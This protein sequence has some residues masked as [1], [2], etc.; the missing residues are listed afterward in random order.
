MKWWLIAVLVAACLIILIV[1]SAA[2]FNSPDVDFWM[3]QLKQPDNVYAS[4]CG[5]RD[6][7][8]ADKTDACG[9]TDYI[10]ALFGGCALVAI[11]T[12]TR[13]MPGRCRRRP[14]AA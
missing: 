10:P 12:D 3:A 11:I 13:I 4:C 9:D 1:K 6:A 5:G 14:R 2:H 7:Y 8:Y